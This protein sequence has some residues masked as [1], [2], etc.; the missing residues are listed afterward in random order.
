MSNAVDADFIINMKCINAGVHVKQLVDGDNSGIY[1]AYRLAGGLHMESPL[2]THYVM[3]G[4]YV[5]FIG[6]KAGLLGFC[7]S[8]L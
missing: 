6:N 8:S 7:N 1:S 5:I 3:D 2:D 4:E